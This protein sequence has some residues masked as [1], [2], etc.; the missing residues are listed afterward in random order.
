MFVDFALN[1]VQHITCM[2]VKNGTRLPSPHGPHPTFDGCCYPPPKSRSSPCFAPDSMAR[3][4]KL[5]KEPEGGRKKEEKERLQG[6]LGGSG[7]QRT[8]PPLNDGWRVPV[9]LHSQ[10]DG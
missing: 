5:T 7:T 8:S 10:K 1:E 9:N 6:A 3:L 4:Q 2:R